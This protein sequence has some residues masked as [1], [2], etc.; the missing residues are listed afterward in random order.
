MK[1]KIGNTVFDLD[2]CA[3]FKPEHLRK[4]YNGEPSEVLD[5]LILEVWPTVETPE[6]EAESP[7]K[8]RSK[9]TN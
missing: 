6:P 3:G 1:K 5:A 9:K 7:K 2:F 8:S 4:I